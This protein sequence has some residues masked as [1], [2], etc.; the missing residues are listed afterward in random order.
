MFPLIV[1]AI[2]FIL[3]IFMTFFGVLLKHISACFLG[4]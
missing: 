3:T 4:K 1:L 2:V